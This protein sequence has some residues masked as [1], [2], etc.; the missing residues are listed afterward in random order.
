MFVGVAAAAV[1]PSLELPRYV[2][3]VWQVGV[4]APVAGPEWLRGPDELEDAIALHE[5]WQRGYPGIR[6]HPSDA[7]V[8]YASQFKPGEIKSLR[9]VLEGI[10]NR[11]ARAV[12]TYL[13]D[14]RVRHDLR[15]DHGFTYDP[16]VAFALNEPQLER[17]V[18]AVDRDTGRI[19]VDYS[20]PVVL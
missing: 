10:R 16:G 11:D 4:G 3:R 5:A 15:A 2:R 18:S 1:V 6:L 17:R 7:E 12:A 9:D 8:V 20:R 14:P 13:A 19:T